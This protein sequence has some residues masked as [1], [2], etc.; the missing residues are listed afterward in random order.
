[1]AE[2]VDEVGCDAHH[3]D[4]ADEVQRVSCGEEGAVHFVR[5]DGGGAVV[6]VCM[7]IASHL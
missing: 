1:V 2:V 7:G 3:D 5:A 6:G 4:G